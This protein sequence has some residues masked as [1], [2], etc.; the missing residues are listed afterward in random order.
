MVVECV[1]AAGTAIP[2]LIIF[3]AQH[4]NIAWTTAHATRFS[5]KSSHQTS[6]IHA[7]KWLNTVSERETRSD[8]TEFMEF[9]HYEGPRSHI[10]DNEIACSM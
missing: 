5:T 9:H 6:E 3:Q 10:T 8:D 7:Y 4:I 1:S 2:P